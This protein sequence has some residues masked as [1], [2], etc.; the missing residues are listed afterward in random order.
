M[1]QVKLAKRL[2]TIQHKG[3]TRTMGAD[4][5]KPYIVHP[6]RVAKALAYSE[7]LC[8]AGWLHDIVEDCGIRR[9]DLIE[10]G[11]DYEVIKLVMAVSKLPGENYLDF[12]VRIKN[13]SEMAVILKLADLEDNM[14]SLP[15]GSLLDKYRLA[16]Y[17][18][19][20]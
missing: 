1:D 13:F 17:V 8:A 4:K 7:I 10:E 11:V 9:E 18:L 16:R 5:G 15:E 14:Q 19:M 20:S 3:Q 12:I 6:R 2:A